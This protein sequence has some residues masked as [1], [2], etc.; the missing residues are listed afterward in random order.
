MYHQARNLARKTWINNLSEDVLSRWKEIDKEVIKAEKYVVK[1]REKRDLLAGQMKTLGLDVEE[2][3]RKRMEEENEAGAS[4]HVEP[5]ELPEE[6]NVPTISASS[7]VD[8]VDELED[9]HMMPAASSSAKQTM[10]PTDETASSPAK[11]SQEPTDVPMEVATS[12][13]AKEQTKIS[14]EEPEGRKLITKTKME[15]KPYTCKGIKGYKIGRSKA[16]VLKP[17]VINGVIQA[18][19]IPCNLMAPVRA[20]PCGRDENKFHCPACPER[21]YNKLCDLKVHQIKICMNR[22]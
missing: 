1:L 7:D 4:S 18:M 6:N 14:T 20:L 15:L 22:N 2:L 8:Q 12:S 9:E 19:E 3:S 10:K 17:T 13:P 21:Q 16:M 5:E 11:E